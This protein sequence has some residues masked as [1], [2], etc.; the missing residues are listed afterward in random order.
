MSEPFFR[1]EM[2]PAKHGD[3]LLVE[4]GRARTR[5]ILIDA[6]PIN[7]Y[8][9]V[10]ARLDALPDEDRRVELAVV[11]HVDTDHIE[12]MIR[13][14]APPVVKWPVQPRDVWFNGWRHLVEHDTLGGR[15]GE[16]L[17]A[18]IHER[19]GERWNKAFRGHAARVGATDDGIVKLAD[20]MVLR[21]LSPDVA[22]LEALQKEWRQK[23]A[24]WD[25]DPG[26]LDAAW[27]QLA[28]TSKFHPGEELTLG[29]DD[30]SE[31]LRKQLRGTDSS[32]ANGSSIAFIAQFAGA[33]CLL[34]GDAHAD[35]VCAALRA[36][37][38]TEDAPMVV[39]AIKLAH[40]GS[41]HNLTPELLQ[42]VDAEH[43]L[44]SSNGDRFKHPDAS[45]IEAITIGAR[46]PPTLWFNYRSP[47]TEPWEARAAAS[48]GA[49]RTRYPADGEEGIVVDLLPREA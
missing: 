29:P 27:Q 41:R 30:L 18:L 10:S 7:A 32:T 8:P 13:L 19:V 22:S 12:G 24:E 35:V 38:A 17:S 23:V 49:F 42:L 21:M 5:R 26:D 11:T 37:G 47:F 36:Y 3:A 2:M 34:L 31:K 20:G 1:I 6:G 15:E 14:M 43:F 4:Y 25:F 33:S 44:V 9:Q 45:T 39:D 16:F 28:E 40:H 46:R 48:D